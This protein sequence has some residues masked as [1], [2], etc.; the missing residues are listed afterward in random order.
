MINRWQV[1]YVQPL[2]GYAAAL[3]GNPNLVIWANHRVETSGLIYRL[4]SSMPIFLLCM[5]AELEE[6]TDFKAPTDH[7]WC[8]DLKQSD[9][10]EV[11]EVIFFV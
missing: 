4:P 7:E 11:K 10:D 6:V 9:S 8:L 1:V 5:S 3:G 2:S